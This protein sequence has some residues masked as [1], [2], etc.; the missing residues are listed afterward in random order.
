MPLC[1]SP[2]ALS[3]SPCSLLSV[4]VLAHQARLIGTGQ[5][6]AALF[7]PS[8]SPLTLWAILFYLPGNWHTTFSPL[9]RFSTLLL[10]GCSAFLPFKRT[11]FSF[12]GRIASQLFVLPR[13]LYFRFA[14]I[15]I[16]SGS[17]C[18]SALGQDPWVAASFSC[19]FTLWPIHLLHL[20]LHLEPELK[21]GATSLNTQLMSASV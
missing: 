21:L 12:F 13:L 14:L 4:C 1:L 19:F 3:D 7:S 15:V 17:L 9:F 11:S 2:F 5:S 6:G 10:P 8:F 18:V 16:V 20:H